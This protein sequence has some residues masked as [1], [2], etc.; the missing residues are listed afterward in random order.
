MGADRHRLLSCCRQARVTVSCCAALVL[1]IGLL[2]GSATAAQ[3]PNIVII[4]GDDGA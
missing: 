4:Y 1:C 3:S 2:T